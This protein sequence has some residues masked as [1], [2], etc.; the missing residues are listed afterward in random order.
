MI[1][2]GIDAG[3]KTLKLVILNEEKIVADRV[4]IIGKN[5][6]TAATE[7]AL[8]ESAA[9]AGISGSELRH[10]AATGASR[11]QVPHSSQQFPETLCLAKGI[12]FIIPAFS[13]IVLDVGVHKAL[14]VRCQ[15]GT[16]MGISRSDRCAA[17]SGEYLEMVAEMMDIDIGRMG[18]FY[19]RS[20]QPVEIQSTC[21][22]FAESEIISLM[23]QQKRPEDILKGAIK[24]FVARLYPLLLSVGYSKENSVVA[25]AGGVA[26]N[27]GIIQALEEQIGR[28]VI[29]PD[30]SSVIGALGAALM[31]RERL[32][33]Q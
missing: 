1:V 33:S 16:P 7:R 11:H 5:S 4:N 26:H 29:V 6:I 22:V 21:S 32:R 10:I 3:L 8:N 27:S 31:G 9:A 30:K 18:E 28:S 14:A 23:H 24:G 2:T 12:D 17:G 25:I 15:D 13:G 20:L 19:Q